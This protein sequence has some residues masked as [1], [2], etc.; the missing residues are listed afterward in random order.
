MWSTI[1]TLIYRKNTGCFLEV[2]V[3]SNGKVAA[4]WQTTFPEVTI[5]ENLEQFQSVRTLERGYICV[6][7]SSI[8]ERGRE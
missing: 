4:C 6:F 2:V 5:Y 1:R 8:I 3:F 7:D